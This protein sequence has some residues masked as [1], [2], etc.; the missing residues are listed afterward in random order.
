MKLD[1][2]LSGTPDPSVPTYRVQGPGCCWDRACTR[3]NRTTALSMSFCPGQL[4]KNEVQLTCR[5]GSSV[6]FALASGLAISGDGVG[7]R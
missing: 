3:F 7:V 4:Q 5:G 1:E 2:H 6:S